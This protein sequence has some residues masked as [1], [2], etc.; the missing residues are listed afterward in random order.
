ME[1]KNGWYQRITSLAAVVAG[2]F[3]YALTVKL[4][5]LPAG[6]VTGGNDRYGAYGKLPDGDTDFR[7]CAY[8]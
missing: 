4:F 5:L 1:L 3:L 6:L 2:N 8:F 7:I